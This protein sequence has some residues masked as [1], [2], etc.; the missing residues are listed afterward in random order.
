M[1]R[2]RR[3]VGVCRR[4]PSDALHLKS[5]PSDAIG[6]I[7]KR[8]FEIDYMMIAGCRERRESDVM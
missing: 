6:A 7:W 1:C 2:S 3:A 4:Q 5:E 8:R